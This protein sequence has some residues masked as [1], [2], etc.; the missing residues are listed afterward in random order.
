MTF[1]G[2]HEGAGRLRRGRVREGFLRF[3]TR[4]RVWGFGF[5]A[6]GSRFRV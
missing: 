5:G 2:T 1:D 3:P 4:V 6:W